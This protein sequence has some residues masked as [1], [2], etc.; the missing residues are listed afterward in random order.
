[1]QRAVLLGGSLFVEPKCFGLVY[2]FASPGAFLLGWL[3]DRVA[4]IRDI[5]VRRRAGLFALLGGLLAC[6]GQAL[7]LRGA[8][9][10]QKGEEAM[11]SEAAGQ[12]RLP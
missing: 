10:F 8:R 2:A 1:M 4:R 9:P 11:G 6:G 12:E 5:C 3:D 7:S